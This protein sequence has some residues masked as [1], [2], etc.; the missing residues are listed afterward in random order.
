MIRD[1]VEKDMNDQDKERE[2]QGLPL[3]E[4]EE[5]MNMAR[6]TESTILKR[7]AEYRVAGVPLRPRHGATPQ[8]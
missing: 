3:T 8:V 2:K 7:E 4:R 1:T 5:L 6:G